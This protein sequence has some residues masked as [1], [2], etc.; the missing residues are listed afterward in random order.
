MVLALGAVAR[1]RVVRDAAPQLGAG[2]RD[3]YPFSLSP[4]CCTPTT[5]SNTAVTSVT[6]VSPVTSPPAAYNAIHHGPTPQNHTRRTA[7]SRLRAD[8]TCRQARRHRNTHTG[9]SPPETVVGEPGRDP[10]VAS[11]LRRDCIQL[12][13]RCHALNAL[14]ATCRLRALLHIIR[15]IRCIRY[16]RYIRYIRYTRYIRLCAQRTHLHIIPSHHPLRTPPRAS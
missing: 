10:P 5:R 11:T 6:S 9:W 3:R 1:E 14:A 15:Y 8:R 12:A 13:R 16:S 2:V 7:V 4:P